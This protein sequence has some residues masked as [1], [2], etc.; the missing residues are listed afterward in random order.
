[1][2]A[3]LLVHPH[4]VHL[5]LVGDLARILRRDDD[6]ASG[7]VHVPIQ[8]DGYSLIGDCSIQCVFVENDLIHGCDLAGGQHPHFVASGDLSRYHSA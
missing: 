8:G 2:V 5:E 7:A 3:G 1:M 4:Q 6:V